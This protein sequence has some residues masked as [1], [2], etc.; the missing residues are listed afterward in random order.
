MLH[1]EILTRCARQNDKKKSIIL[2]VILSVLAKDLFFLPLQA[3]H[4]VEQS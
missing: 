4:F 1:C 2:N 3:E